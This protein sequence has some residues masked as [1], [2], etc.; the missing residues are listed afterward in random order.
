MIRHVENLECDAEGKERVSET[1]PYLKIML[2]WEWI[3]LSSVQPQIGTFQLS[4]RTSSSQLSSFRVPGWPVLL[5]FGRGAEWRWVG[6]RGGA[7][8]R[9]FE[10][11]VRFNGISGPH[12]KLRISL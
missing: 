5:L 9:D 4:P 8:R 7:E 10:R 11:I 1:P 12:L 6:S 3:K 2:D